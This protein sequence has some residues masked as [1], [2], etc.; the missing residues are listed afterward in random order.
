MYIFLTFLC[1]K[2]TYSKKL[3][4]FCKMKAWMNHG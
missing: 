2:V 3:C 4:Y 1:E